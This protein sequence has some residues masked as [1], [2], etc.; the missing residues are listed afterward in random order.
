[1]RESCSR[2]SAHSRR[3]GSRLGIRSIGAP[4]GY[5]IE[6]PLGVEM[7]GEGQHV[8]YRAALVSLPPSHEGYVPATTPRL[9]PAIGAGVTPIVGLRI[10]GS[11]TVGSYLNNSFT[12]A[13]LR[14]EGW[15]DY[16]Q[17]LVALD[18]SF[19]HGYL[20]THAEAARG[21]Y[22]VPG[23]DD[24]PLMGYTYYG[25]AKYTLTPRFFVAG[26]AERNN[27]PFV[28]LFGTNWTAKLTDFVDGE[29]GVG[30]RLN[31]TTLAKVSVRADRWWV[32]PGASR[33]P[34]SGRPGVGDAGVEVVRCDELVCAREIGRID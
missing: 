9:R 7:S 31:Q 16:H 19:S 23:H 28:R 6:Y 33:V 30:Y 32:A 3:V 26:R 29:L 13:Q 22:D 2:S 25:E 17:R 20:E 1:M 18:L 34:R 15:S 21:S 8:D 5:S 10:G 24:H 14:N 4:D 12:A 27:Y 11:F